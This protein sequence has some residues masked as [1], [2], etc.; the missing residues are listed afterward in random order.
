MNPDLSTTARARL[1]AASI[2]PQRYGLSVFLRKAYPAVGNGQQST[3]DREPELRL[4]GAPVELVTWDDIPADVGE[5]VRRKVSDDTFAAFH[6]LQSAAVHRVNVEGARTLG[7]S[8]VPDA[9]ILVDVSPGS[10][11]VVTEREGAAERDRDLRSSLVALRVGEGAR[12]QWFGHSVRAPGFA[13]V[14]RLAIL[15]R[16]AVLEHHSVLLAAN[17]M[18]ENVHVVLGAPGATARVNT[19]FVGN[20][21][22]QFDLGIT[23]EHQAPHTVSNLAAKGVLSGKAQ[24]VVRGLVR[25]EREAP[26]SDGY[27]RCD[28]LLLSPTAEVDPVPNLEI[29]TNDVRCTHGVATGHLNPEQL[30]YLQSRGFSDA[31]ACDLLVTGFVGGMLR[32]W[33]EVQREDLGAAVSEILRGS[34]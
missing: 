21:E 31:A 27:Q 22:H 5:L 8:V 10:Q 2:P 30:F 24:A 13:V 28:T 20:H 4:R 26:G 7:L 25:V 3:G 15:A 29:R 16:D 14:E 17:A 34:P 18:R 12:V 11:L 32:A 6:V 33:P 9:T 1:A 23:A 19:L